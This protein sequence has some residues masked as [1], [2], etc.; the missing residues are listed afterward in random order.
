MGKK[1][2]EKYLTIGNAPN[3]CPN[4][5]ADMRKENCAECIHHDVFWRGSGCNLLNNGERCKFEGRRADNRY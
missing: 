2:G 1:C 5:G 4:C 3:F